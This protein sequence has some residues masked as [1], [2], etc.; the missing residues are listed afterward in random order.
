[1]AA[2]EIEIE[3]VCL[4]S[5]RSHLGDTGAVTW[6]KRFAEL[7]AGSKPP[8]NVAEEEGPIDGVIKKAD[9]RHKI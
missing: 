4:G 6:L 3:T 8:S 2:K 9:D 5:E 7:A 1:M